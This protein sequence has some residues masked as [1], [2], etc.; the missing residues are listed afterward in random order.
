MIS[1]LVSLVVVCACVSIGLALPVVAETS[2]A[3]DW[4]GR[5]VVTPEGELLGRI[6]DLAVDVEAKR[7]D[8]VVVSIGSFLVDNNLIAVDPDALG[9]SDDGAYLVVYAENLDTAARFGMENWPSQ[10]DVMP[11]S[12]R[13]PVVVEIV[14]ASDSESGSYED[15]RA[16]ISDGRRTSTMTA[17]EDFAR[18][19]RSGDGDSQA[20]Q[21]QAQVQPKQFQ[22]RD[23]AQPL[24]ADSEFERMDEN[25]D[26]Y[27][28]R[29]EIGARLNQ[30]VRYQDYDLDGNDGIDSFEFQIL[31]ERG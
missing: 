31:K 7:V 14:A 22:A 4:V 6:E 30:N 24:L 10:A 15:R 8:F 27:L 18:I 11:S 23:S 25:G 9:L 17:G 28:S 3:S 5:V 2:K 13:A 12:E 26:G 29:S 21:T 16:T 1:R 19:E 20:V